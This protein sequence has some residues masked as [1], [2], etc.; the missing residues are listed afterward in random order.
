MT[1]LIHACCA[2]CLLYPAEVL[3]SEQ[4]SFTCYFFNPN[5]HPYKEFQ[6]R[7]KSFSELVESRGYTKII[8]TQYGLKAFLR[9]VVFREDRRCSSCYFMRLSKTFETA[10]K[11][12]FSSVTS[13]LLYS[14][15]QNHS[16]LRAT[17]EKLSE[18]YGIDYF[19][20]DFRLGWQKGIQESKAL[21]LYRQSY[22][23][24]IYSEQERYD[25]R[26]NG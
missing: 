23:G 11:H 15:Y 1:V 8:D 16:C 6:L 14:K 18:V 4:V 2:P 24:C 9:S 10:R 21:D 13:T 22:C 7:L 20:R 19:Y 3:S 5:I 25:K 12:D 17:L 26:I